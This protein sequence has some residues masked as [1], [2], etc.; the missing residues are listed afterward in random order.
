[1]IVRDYLEKQ[2]I[3]RP[4]RPAILFKEEK[5]TFSDL[6]TLSNRLANRFLNLGIK[7]GDRVV[8]LFQN[9]PEFCVAY[10]AILKIGAIAVILDFRLSPAEMEPLFQEAEVTAIVTSVRQKVFIDRVLKTVPTLQH[11]VVAGVEGEDIRNWHSY[12][13]IIGK[14][15]SENISIP[16]QE[17]DESLYLYTSGTTGRSKGVILTNSHLSYFPE[18][19]H[20]ALS[21]SEKDTWGLVLP[22]SHIS[23]PVLMNLLVETGLSVSIVDEMKPKRI[24][25]AI[26]NHRVTVFHAVP[27]I[28]QLILNIPHWERYDC[29]S[30]TMACMMGTVVPESLMREFWERYPHLQPFQAYGAT[31]TSPLLTIT[32]LKDAQ[33][34][35]ASAGKVVPRAELKI[36]GQ[37]GKEVETGQMG[38]IIA[39]GPQIMK[40][41]LKDPK[42]T[43]K[44]IKDGWYHSGDLGRFDEEGYLYVLGRADEMVVS[45]GLNVY[46]S[47]V[48]TVLLNH[49]KVQEAAVVGIPDS[50]RGQI[51]RAN[52][53]LKHGETATHREIL[54][55]CKERL[56]S[57][58][59]PRQLEFKDSLPKSR[60]GKIA[61]R[62]LRTIETTYE[63]WRDFISEREAFIGPLALILIWYVISE[64]KW[65]NPFFLPSPWNV[66]LKL[67]ELLLSGTVYTHIGKTIYRMFIGYFLAILLGI[68]L[69]IIV[70]YWEKAY[71]SLEFVIEFF[72]GFPATSLFPLFMLAFGIGDAAKIA[73]VVFSC[74]LV[75]TINTLYG[76]RNSSKTR[77][78]VA[79][80]MKANKTYIF[81][82]VILPD[83]LPY[84]TAGLRT[85]LSLTLI[86]IVILE[87]FIGTDKGLGHLIYNANITY[88]IPQM[89]ATIIITGFIGYGMN[90][91][92]I[93]LEEEVIHWGGR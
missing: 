79:E 41:Y 9:C 59:M 62:Q 16:L 7:K 75:I 29:S 47:E 78:M 21:I 73:I 69:G 18:S 42:A 1:M 82:R 8:L 53:V 28:F 40:G 51:L 24:L 34:K 63:K 70:G 66:L 58:K 23:G 85:A 6:N 14:E 64:F 93:K 32:H 22:I 39:R 50:R 43:A 20:H 81:A 84:I 49:P 87:M 15:S 2:A 30:L 38:E 44:K 13:E 65:V 54:S 10:F 56:A 45:G 71:N 25:D 83:S 80:T 52:V 89:Y 72:R 4:N 35:M 60:T 37:D 86:I 92:F 19:C 74:S 76:V 88:Q 55:F 17:E 26:Q 36:I 67:K 5:I 33:R 11:I 68:P 77:Q 3:E 27:P 91:G 61:K 12:E 46:P 31:E 48:E 90:K 57:F